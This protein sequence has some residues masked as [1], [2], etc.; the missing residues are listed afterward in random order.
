MISIWKGDIGREVGAGD[1]DVR[2]VLALL[3]ATSIW[4][5]DVTTSSLSRKH[6]GFVQTA[7]YGSAV[8]RF[9]R[10][11]PARGEHESLYRRPIT[12]TAHS[13]LPRPQYLETAWAEADVPNSG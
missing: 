4:I 11:D 5:C 9:L 10:G 13:Y 2:Y 3:T 12:R 1:D 8:L 7:S 6:L